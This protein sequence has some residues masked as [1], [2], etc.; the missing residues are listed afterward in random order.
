MKKY[1]SHPCTA[2][3]LDDLLNDKADEGMKPVHFI[4]AGA[5]RRANKLMPGQETLMPMLIVVF[6]RGNIIHA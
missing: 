5:Q 1:E 4:M 2:D 3:N 6:E